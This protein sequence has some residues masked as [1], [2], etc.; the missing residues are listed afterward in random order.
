MCG[1]AISC[2]DIG[3]WPDACKHLTFW[4]VD[5]AQIVRKRFLVFPKI[6]EQCSY[7][8]VLIKKR[9]VPNQK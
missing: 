7:K 2:F 9:V 4:L 8:I 5:E 3:R 6:E 1:F